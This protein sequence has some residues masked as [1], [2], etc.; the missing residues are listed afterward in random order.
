VHAP[1]CAGGGLF[2][3]GCALALFATVLFLF[4]CDGVVPLWSQGG[5]AP[6]PPNT[7]SLAQK[8]VRADPRFAT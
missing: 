6:W 4:D 5:T 7:S 3:V 8:S 1:A 2:C